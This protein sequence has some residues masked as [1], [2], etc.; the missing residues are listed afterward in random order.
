MTRVVILQKYLAPYRVPVFN[1]IAGHPAVNLTVL[2]YGKI[3]AR[4]KWSAFDAPEFAEVQARCVS[5]GVGYEW[6]LELPLSLL[7]DLERIRPDVIICAPDSGGIA[8][9]LYARKA[10]ASIC[11]WSEATP[12]TEQSV[13]FPKRFLRRKLCRQAHGFLVPGSL[14][15]TYIREYRP[16][17]KVFRAPNAID[18]E[19]FSVSREQLPAKFSSRRVVITFSGSLVER[20]GIVLL[21]EAFHQLLREQPALRDDCL[22]RVM[23]TG[24]LDLAR[25][26]GNPVTFTGFCENETYRTHFKESHIFVLPSLHDN[27][28]LT[29]VEGLFSGNVMLLADGVGNHPEAVRGNGLVVPANSVEDL[30]RGLATLLSLPRTELLRMS[31]VSLA[32]ATEFSVTRSVDG[33]LAAIRVSEADSPPSGR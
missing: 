10:G 32:I 8:A 2:Y 30:K 16:S 26:H 9:A 28:P 31:A 22:L 23:G 20:K 18:E 4:R 6:N 1:G 11:I 12:V 5:I 25:Y 3:E 14:A 15:E 33:F 21:L 24:P 27:N 7:K 17:A 29:V 19:R 13:S